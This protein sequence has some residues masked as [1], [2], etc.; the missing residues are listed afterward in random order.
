MYQS[1]ISNTSEL[2][3]KYSHIED[4]KTNFYTQ[5]PFL[6]HYTNSS[7]L[8]G[9]IRNSSEEKG[10]LHL[11]FSRSDCLNDPSE[12]CHI[13]LLYKK[14][15]KNL[16]NDGQID[17]SYYDLV[18]E[19]ELSKSV[20]FSYPLP[21]ENKNTRSSMLDCTDCEAYICSF[22]LAEDSLDLWRY[23]AKENDGYCLKFSPY[24]FK[25]KRDYSF[26]EYNENVIFSNIQGFSVIYDDKE[27]EKMISELLIDTYNLYQ[28]RYNFKLENERFTNFLVNILKKYQFR[29]KHE[30]YSSEKEYRYVFYRPMKKP[31][32]LKNELPKIN[33]RAKNGLIIP[34]L[35]I[36]IEK[37]AHYLRE[38]MISPFNKNESAKDTLTD[39][40]T[41]CGFGEIKIS[42][43][44]LPVRD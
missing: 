41:N 35:D 24:K 6:Y 40:V 5:Y 25:A 42:K 34:Y 43:S 37:D 22:S 30:C 26:L 14:I 31:T 16:V 28:N 18:S 12:G 8:L 17:K 7:G 13:I 33:Y 23:Y 4:K 32:D 9:I 27:K 10:K 2:Y 11:W 44:E 39:Y 19:L 36:E 29:F 38:I 3:K 1:T 15:C 21:E 20:F